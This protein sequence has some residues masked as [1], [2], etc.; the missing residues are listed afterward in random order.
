M[1]VV[2][3]GGSGH[4]GR[5]LSR[6]LQGQGHEVVVLSRGGAPADLAP[7]GLPPVRFVPWDGKTLGP[8]AGEIDGADVVLNLAGRSVRCRYHEA[9]KREMMDSR[10]LSTRAVGAAI[11]AAKNPPRLWLQMST[12]AIYAHRFDAPHDEATGVLGGGEPGAPREWDFSIAI[13]RAWEK[14]V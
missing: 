1:K 14:E 6:E 7:Q 3:P 9:N 10:V 11:R 5:L 12:S 8:W 2:I 13:G 4:V